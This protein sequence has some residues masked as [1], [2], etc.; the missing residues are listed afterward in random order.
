MGGRRNRCDNVSGD[1][2]ICS[3]ICT[4]GKTF[5]TITQLCRDG[6]F[7]PSPGN[8]V[9]DVF[10]GMVISEDRVLH[11]EPND[12]ILS[13][14]STT[15]PTITNTKPDF[16]KSFRLDTAEPVV[17]GVENARRSGSTKVLESETPLT[18]YPDENTHKRKT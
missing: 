18:N 1:Y 16:V 6:L 12:C 14:I 17:S 10:A 15:E 13:S 2:E 5:K 11:P 3:E 7:E 8:V 4:K 9:K